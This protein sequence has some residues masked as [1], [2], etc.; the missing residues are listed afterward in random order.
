[1]YTI[2]KNLVWPDFVKMEKPFTI[3]RTE[4]LFLSQSLNLFVEQLCVLSLQAMFGR[5]SSSYSQIFRW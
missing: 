2:R 5:E 1:M 3:E 4:S